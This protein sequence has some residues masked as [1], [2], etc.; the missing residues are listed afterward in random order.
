MRS[1]SRQL[2]KISPNPFACVLALALLACGSDDGGG[3]SEA[4][5]DPSATSASATATTTGTDSAGTDSDSG[6]ET[7]GDTGGSGSASDSS[8]SS[9]DTQGPNAADR[10]LEACEVDGDCEVNGLD[11]G[12]NCVDSRCVRD[13]P[14]CVSNGQCVATT[15]GW[16]AECAS[17]DDCLTGACVDI[18]GGEGRCAT[19]PTTLTP[20]ALLLL[21]ELLYPPI[22]GGED[23]AVCGRGA[24]ICEEDGSCGFA[25][26]SDAQCL[27]PSA[28]ACDPDSGACECTSDDDCA[29]VPGASICLA[30]SCGC[31][32]DADCEDV[33]NADTCQENG[34]CGCSSVDACTD[35]RAFDGTDF[36][37]APA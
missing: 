19:E 5:V 31:A 33:D 3:D 26:S 30:G 34:V 4:T 24:A 13:E 35:E 16:L 12:F 28:P 2:P 25:C 17:Q 9:G 10:C 21:E 1:A 23:V 22:E 27:S 29:D 18:G 37:C 32:T 8:G 14:A 7:T 11:V 15:S 20:C 36:V 6:G